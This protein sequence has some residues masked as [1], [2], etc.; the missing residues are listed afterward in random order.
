[1]FPSNAS[2]VCPGPPSIRLKCTFPQGT[3]TVVWTSPGSSNVRDEP[4][5][6]I[7]N[8]MIGSGVS[9]LDVNSSSDLKESYRC[10]ATFPNATSQES[11]Q[12]TKREPSGKLSCDS[13]MHSHCMGL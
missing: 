5:H 3:T 9:Y 7:D 12:M 4:G 2:Y 1:M 11:S 10:I 6:V 8:S 13:C